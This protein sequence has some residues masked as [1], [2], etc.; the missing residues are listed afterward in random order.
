MYEQ[1]KRRLS[2]LIILI[3]YTLFAAAI[4]IE[5]LLLDWDFRVILEICV[6][7]IVCWALHITGKVPEAVERWMFFALGMSGYIFYG[8]HGTSV[9]DLA[10]VMILMI[11]VYYAADAYDMI[12]LCVVVYLAVLL[13]GIA[14][15]FRETFD[16][17]VLSVS[18]LVLHCV[19]VCLAAYMTKFMSDRRRGEMKDTTEKIANMEEA[20][21]R[22]EDFLTNVSHEL[23][24]PVNVVTGLASVMIK[25]EADGVKRENLQSIE[26]AGYRLFGQIED[27][28]DYTEIDAGKIMACE[29]P[30]ML[31]SLINDIIT[32]Q[33]A[34][35]EKPGVE[36]IFD[37]DARIPAVLSGDGRKIKKIIRH[38]VNNAVKFTEEGGVYVRIYA[39]PKSYGVNLCIQVTDTG[40]G[41]DADN[42]SRITERF[43]QSSRG[44]D[45]KAGG[46]GLGLPIVYGMVAAVKGFVHMESQLGKGTTVTVSIPQKVVDETPG[47]SVNDPSSLCLAC[48]LMPEKYKVPEV[49]RFYD[50]M[51]THIAVG[52]EITAHRVFRQDELERLVSMYRL[53]HLFIA[54]CFPNLSTASR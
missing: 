2:H 37:V 45:R 41:I 46:L 38:L 42:L 50:E 36:I 47:M 53:T 30:Y 5:G 1:E 3:S 18:R 28:L 20:N 10:P 29:E 14:F 44:R 17:N 43:Y 7:L 35:E 32:E 39:L 15:S 31:S 48:Y 21:R 34:I 8:G 22:T 24:T 19:L 27:I 13:Y 4:L 26:K 33:Y 51:I 12:R 11:I 52:L 40:I 49:R 6:A 16:F 9:Y 25:S 23:R 54:R